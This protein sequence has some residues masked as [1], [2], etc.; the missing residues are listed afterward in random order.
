MSV[1]VVLATAFLIIS[2]AVQPGRGTPS[3]QRPLS[4]AVGTQTTVPT[5][6]QPAAGDAG[7]VISEQAL[8]YQDMIEAYEAGR[9]EEARRL[10]R[11]HLARTREGMAAIVS[12]LDREAIA[13]RMLGILDAM[14]G[15]ENRLAAPDRFGRDLA[16]SNFVKE[17]I[18][19]V[20]RLAGPNLQVS[21]A[22]RDFLDRQTGVVAA[23]WV[24]ASI[25]VVPRAEVE[26]FYQEF[27]P[28]LRTAGFESF[29]EILEAPATPAPQTVQAQ[30]VALDERETASLMAAIR[31]YFEGLIQGDS[32]QLA[33]ATGLD[34]DAAAALVAAVQTDY[35]EANIA[36]VRSITVPDQPLALAADGDVYV[37]R[38][39]GI[40]LDAV[41]SDGRT[42][43][44]RMDKPVTVRK[45]ETGQWFVIPPQ[46]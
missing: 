13:H 36:E 10:A 15:A 37:V 14:L 19:V 21:A 44:Q 42:V 18:L 20:R 46:Q 40:T 27:A 7:T 4:T 41:L 11:T 33:Q 28:E 17:Q 34:V 12:D 25:D 30:T 8:V 5:P 3:V 38:L 29:A 1:G 6:S 45:G 32:A 26:S 22:V 39:N 16:L 43:T 9:L 35:A 23:G 24:Q 31:G 2:C